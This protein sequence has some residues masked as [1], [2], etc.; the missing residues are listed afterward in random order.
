MVRDYYYELSDRGVLTLD[1]VVQDDPWFCDFFF[2]RVAPTA[3][4][5]Y[6]EYPFVCRCGDEMNYLR[7]ADTP[8]VYTG[9]DG[10]RLS[11]GAS[12]STPFAPDRLLYSHD[13]VL[14]HWAPV[15]DVGRIV[16]HVA[17]E[18][19]QRIEPWGPYYAY[20]GD[21]G[22]EMIPVMPRIL[23]R[24][25]TV[26][27][28]RRDNSC[29]GCGQANP[30][31][32]RLS[33]VVDHADA[34]VSTWLRPDLRFQGAMETTHGGM[35]SL[36]LDEAMGK[37]LSAQGIKGPTA[38]LGVNFRRPMIL[39]EEYCIRA[40]IREQQGR[41]KFVNADVRAWNDPD[42]VIAN[43]DALFIERAPTPPA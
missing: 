10:S 25:I 34:S 16:P 33:F 9:F 2:R 12:L 35:I 23:D 22:R 28:P 20:V 31:S 37:A 40:W 38:H 11:Y 17:T 41:K 6:P 18:I 8:I 27:R 13:G 15:G 14:Y 39:G 26:L 7:P 32:L 5:E 19:A 29:V 43:A 4:P 36:L 24:E 3:N 30:F 42:V 1:G 21:D